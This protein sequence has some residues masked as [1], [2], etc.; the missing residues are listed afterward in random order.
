MSFLTLGF[1]KSII[2]PKEVNYYENRPANKISNINIKEFVNGKLQDELELALADQIPFSQ[3]MKKYYNLYSN[4][5]ADKMLNLC[6]KQYFNNPEIVVGGVTE[7]YDIEIILG[8]M[9]AN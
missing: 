1:I 6:I 9:D 7:G 4:S 3:R 5:V 2:L 8:T